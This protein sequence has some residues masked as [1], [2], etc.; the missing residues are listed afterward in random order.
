MTLRSGSN[1]EVR[2]YPDRIELSGDTASIHAEAD[3]ILACFRFSSH[4]YCID[5]DDDN[6]VV[7]RETET[8]GGTINEAG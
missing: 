8:V 5:R 2:Y 4:P 3:R 6:L 1:M 7:L